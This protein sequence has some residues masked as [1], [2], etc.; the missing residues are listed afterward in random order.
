MVVF[1]CWEVIILVKYKT[2]FVLDYATY[3]KALDVYNGYDDEGIV[4]LYH[5]TT[6]RL[7]SD[8]LYKEKNLLMVRHN[9]EERND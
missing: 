1:E 8:F 3:E 7:S 4:K 5:I 9:N 6:S 2:E